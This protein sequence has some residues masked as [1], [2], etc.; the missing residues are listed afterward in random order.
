MDKLTPDVVF[1]LT[2]FLVPGFLMAFWINL[3]VPLRPSTDNTNFITYVF[4]SL[5]L[6]I[7]LFFVLG[8]YGKLPHF[9]SFHQMLGW[10]AWFVLIGPF[11][12]G[13]S[14]SRA[15]HRR[16]HL[17][18]TFFEKIGVRPVSPIASAWDKA[19]IRDEPAW[20]IVTLKGGQQIAGLWEAGAAASSD[21]G[22]RDLFFETVYRIPPQRIVGEGSTKS[23]NDY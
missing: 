10:G 19:F 11:L 15:I 22:E 16:D 4:L 13:Y 2:L 17:L 1:Y 23:W 12:F 6:G 21:P 20:L 14:M 9:D 5:I 7:P 18:W 3:F 8:W